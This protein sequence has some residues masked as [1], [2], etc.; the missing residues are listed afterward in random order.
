MIVADFA[1]PAA[2][3]VV[4]IIVNITIIITIIIIIIIIPQYSLCCW[5][6]FKEACDQ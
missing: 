5:A 3:A 1:R 6:Q 4:T 2:A